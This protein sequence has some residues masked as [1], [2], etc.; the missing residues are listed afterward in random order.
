MTKKP[1]LV[2][3]G[4]DFSLSA[5]SVDLNLRVHTVQFE[6]NVPPS[7]TVTDE[8]AYFA[9]GTAVT[10]D[11]TYTGVYTGSNFSDRM[12]GDDL[13]NLFSGGHGNDFLYGR[14]GVDALNGDDGNDFIA[15]GAGDDLLAG[16]AG[17]DTINGGAD[18]DTL[19]GG[20]DSDV[21]H[22]GT[23][24]DLIYG[25]SG[26]RDSDGQDHTPGDTN[27]AL[28]GGAGNDTIYGNAGDDYLEGG[29]G[30]DRLFGND[31][32]TSP[33]VGNDTI[34]G[35]AGDDIIGGFGGTST[36]Y[37]DAGNDTILGGD[38]ND[39]IYG[40][41]GADIILASTGADWMSAN[42][43]ITTGDGARDT[44][45]FFSGHSPAS[46]QDTIQGFKHGEDIIDLEESHVALILNDAPGSSGTFVS[47]EAA[48][49][50]LQAHSISAEGAVV[51]VDTGS[52]GLI[53]G[54][55]DAAGT[56]DLNVSVGETAAAQMTQ[57]DF[58]F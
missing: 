30:N 25:G 9:D 34:H 12:I 51:K 49:G 55:S 26:I 7:A 22:G 42:N 38:Q 23:G 4:P 3:V 15:G 17:N 56:I 6:E 52:S 10:T 8:A 36:L 19:R 43:G 20:I 41:R 40:G 11:F 29:A 44:F 18:N 53:V 45:V 21:I 1:A 32:A 37:G 2:S 5:A 24:D 33:T 57:S 14:A 50:Y 13:T 48:L 58:L 46:V 39:T 47:S 16:G 54:F 35:G 31:T 27:D 28:Y